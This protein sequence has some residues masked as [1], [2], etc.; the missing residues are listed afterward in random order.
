MIKTIIKNS[1]MLVAPT[2]TETF[3]QSRWS[4]ER[5]RQLRKDCDACASL[6]QTVDTVMACPW[7]QP[8]QKKSEILSLLKMLE[9]Q[10]PKRVCEIGA[11]GGGTLS[12][13]SAVAAPTARL[14]SVDIGFKP[15]QLK[16][17][18]TLARARQEITCLK[19]D[20]HL[21]QTLDKVKNW[22]AGSQ[23]DFLFIDGDHSLA[24]VTNDYKMYG[25]LVRAGGMIA[26]HDIVPD[27]KARLGM[28]TT[29]D[30]GQV[31]SFW[32]G[33]KGDKTAVCELVEDP[34]Q[35]GYGIGLFTC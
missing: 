10:K 34:C 17:Y 35:D 31:P 25:P 33:L 26:F 12:L 20:S 19:A 29:N 21:T 3:R 32:N 22:L 4:V 5:A 6:D 2:W 28:P 24:G 30:V 23:L 13:F 18:P 16:A 9:H 8:T 15:S 27:F 1:L 14:L 7:F 11:S